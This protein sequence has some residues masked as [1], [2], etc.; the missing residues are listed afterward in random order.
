M[1]PAKATQ[2][3]GRPFRPA[4]ARSCSGRLHVDP[5]GSVVFA[6]RLL[7]VETTEQYQIVQ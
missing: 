1:L 7:Y 5:F 6:P 4:S 2:M 3:D